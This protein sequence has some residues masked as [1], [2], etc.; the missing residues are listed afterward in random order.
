MN[1]PRLEKQAAFAAYHV[2]HGRSSFGFD[3]QHFGNGQNELRC[4]LSSRIIIT[5]CVMSMSGFVIT[6]DN[7]E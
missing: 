5:M 6:I 1:S 2:V 3:P 7:W 4:S